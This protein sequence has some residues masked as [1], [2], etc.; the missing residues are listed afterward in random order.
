M[1]IGIKPRTRVVGDAQLKRDL[2]P[3]DRPELNTYTID[4]CL[5]RWEREHARLGMEARC[6]V[7]S[8][9]IQ[10][11]KPALIVNDYRF[12]GVGSL[13]VTLSSYV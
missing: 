13:H 4:I 11:F 9:R 12:T 7:P 8:P 3:E 10:K 5:G 6:F 2:F 1:N